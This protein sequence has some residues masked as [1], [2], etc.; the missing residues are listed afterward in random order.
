MFGDKHILMDVGA[1][2]YPRFFPDGS[3]GC[4]LECIL[5]NTCSQQQKFNSI[6]LVF[7]LFKNY[8]F[9]TSSDFSQISEREARYSLIQDVPFQFQKS[10]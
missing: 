4:S 7:V 3:I 6:S 2:S 8:Y 9:V 5:I 10:V 1:F